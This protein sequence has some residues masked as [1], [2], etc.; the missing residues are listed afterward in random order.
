V[1]ESGPGF[2]AWCD[3]VYTVDALV[4]TVSALHIPDSLCSVTIMRLGAGDTW[5]NSMPLDEA[6]AFIR[7]SFTA[8]SY[9]HAFVNV[10]LSSGAILDPSFTCYSKEYRRVYPTEPLQGSVYDRAYFFVPR[11]ELVLGNGPRSMAVEAAA[12]SI[13]TQADTEHILL[14]LCAPDEKKRVLTGACSFFTEWVAPLETC[15]TYH[16]DTAAIARDIALSWVHLHDGD[17][18]ACV[19]GLS[20]EALAARVDAAPKG[21]RV[22]I[23]TSL[24]RLEKYLQR[25]NEATKSW[26]TRPPRPDLERK[27][28]RA[29]GP[30]DKELTREQILQALEVKPATLLEALEAA[31]VP[32]DEWLRIEPLALE[33]IEAKS[34][35]APTIEVNMTTGHHVRFIEQHAPYHVRRLSNGGVLL[36]T[37]PYR[38]LWQLWADALLLLGIRT[39]AGDP[40]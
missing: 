16:A 39:D 2:Y 3:E 27:G 9:V 23:A 4:G 1:S 40:T 28:P 33:M 11:V 13:H 34:Q 14:G 10:R 22:G 30:G 35:G 19:A 20:L 36:A 17:K 29:I 26:P 6:I 12:V 32:D 38:T 25:D 21:A 37:H 31:A 24:E 8:G 18:T 15:A 7:A 5:R